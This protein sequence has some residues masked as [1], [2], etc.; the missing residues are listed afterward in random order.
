LSLFV[1]NVRYTDFTENYDNEKGVVA[2]KRVNNV[3]D[4]QRERELRS[5]ERLNAL[6]RNIAMCARLQLSIL[7]AAMLLNPFTCGV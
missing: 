3:R 6:L 4:V 5:A 7:L 1:Y 2:W